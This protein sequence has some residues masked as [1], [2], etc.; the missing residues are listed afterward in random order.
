MKYKN[1]NSAYNLI[2]NLILYWTAKTIFYFN[3]NSDQHIG[4]DFERAFGLIFGP[5]IL[6]HLQVSWAHFFQFI[7]KHCDQAQLMTRGL[8]YQNLEILLSVQSSSFLLPF[9]KNDPKPLKLT[10]IFKNLH[11]P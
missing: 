4:R 5:R 11:L 9:F 8:I 6:S 1:S 10:K 7:L 3:Y 2:K